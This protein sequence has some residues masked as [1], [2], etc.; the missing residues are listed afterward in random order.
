MKQTRL[1]DPKEILLI[2]SIMVQGLY[3]EITEPWYPPRTPIVW[4]IYSGATTSGTSEF[5]DFVHVGDD[6][7]IR[8]IARNRD[9]LMEQSAV[10]YGPHFEVLSILMGCDQKH[11][12]PFI[13]DHY[14]SIFFNGNRPIVILFNIE[15]Q[16]K[17]DT[18]MIQHCFLSWFFSGWFAKFY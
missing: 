1:K 6:S 3:S 8:Y 9:V 16:L 18:L 7:K 14:K 10:G 4:C 5:R 2:F 12:G 11:F 15:K 13:Q 17:S